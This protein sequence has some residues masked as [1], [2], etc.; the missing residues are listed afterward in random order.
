MHGVRL[1]K[2]RRTFAALAPRECAAGSVPTVGLIGYW[3]FDE[4]TGT[5]A[6][7]L[8]ESWYNVQFVTRIDRV[9]KD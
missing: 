2:L 5:L 6:R 1:G 8:R 9:V 4:G 7:P 3:N